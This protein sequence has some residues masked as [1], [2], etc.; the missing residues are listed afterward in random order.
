VRTKSELLA[1]LARSLAL[2]ETFGANWD[3]LSD[4]LQDLTVAPQ[5]IVLHLEHV[6]DAKRALAGEW[7]TFVEILRDAAMYWKERGKAFV[8]FIDDATELPAW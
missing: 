1:T 3:A 5:G 7:L 6:S 8:V 2:P 4:S